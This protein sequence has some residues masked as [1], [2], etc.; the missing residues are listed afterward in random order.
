[1]LGL[2]LWLQL[3]HEHNAKAKATTKPISKSEIKANAKADA[4]ANVNVFAHAGKLSAHAVRPQPISKT[5]YYGNPRN[6]C[7]IS[8]KLGVR[9]LLLI[10]HSRYLLIS[11]KSATQ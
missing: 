8:L 7:V 9:P 6:R 3:K 10:K 5:G 4:A 11:S 1:M 2:K